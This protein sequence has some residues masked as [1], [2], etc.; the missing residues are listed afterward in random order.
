MK[1]ILIFNIITLISESY[2]HI[3]SC[4]S[5]RVLVLCR[6]FVLYVDCIHTN[7]IYQHS[8]HIKAVK[9]EPITHLTESR[10]KIHWL[11]ELLF[12]LFNL[13]FILHTAIRKREHFGKRSFPSIY[14][15]PSHVD[16]GT[17]TFPRGASAVETLFSVCNTTPPVLNEH[18][19]D[20]M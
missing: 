5:T 8:I 14:I 20:V 13:G 18:T 15:I 2:T 7:A 10:N 17:L 4:G 1:R 6:M 16:E 12:I 19:Q 9:H 3:V 11:G